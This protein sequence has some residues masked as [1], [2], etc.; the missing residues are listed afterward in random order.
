MAKLKMALSAP[1]NWYEG[2]I[3]PRKWGTA[4]HRILQAPKEKGI[5][6]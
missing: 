3:D 6:A 4:I 1:Q 5:K 2:G